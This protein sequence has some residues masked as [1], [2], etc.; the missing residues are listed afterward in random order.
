MRVAVVQAGSV[1]SPESSGSATSAD[2]PLSLMTSFDTPA[3]LE[4][5]RSRTAEAA[6]AGAE[7]VVFP[8]AFIAGYPKGADFGVRVGSR[9]AAGRKQFAT[10]FAGAITADGPESA[11]LGGIA[12]EHRVHLVIGVVEREQSTLYCSA[13]IYGP[14][15]TLLG[16][17]RKLVPTAMERVVWGCGDGSTIPVIDT[18]IGRIGSVICWENY[19]PLLRTAMYSR[20]IEFYCAITVDDRDSW[21]PTVRH[22]AMEGRCFVLSACQ[23]VSPCRFIDGAAA[24]QDLPEPRQ[25]VIRGGSC[26]IGPLGEV[27]AGPL[28]GEESI[29]YADLQRSDLIE[30]RFDLDVVGHYARPDVFQLL[31]DERPKPS[32]STVPDTPIPE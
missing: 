26:I 16:R 12:G 13:F 22:I 25:P 9:S 15:G 32:I 6:A 28:Y 4:K 23:F 24:R 21:I 5:T 31:V 1:S 18:P 20:G 29:L 7:L 30:A 8:E 19:M 10:Y 27:L 14:D 11:I 2:S 17:H 3:T